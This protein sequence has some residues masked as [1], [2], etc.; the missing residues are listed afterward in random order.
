MKKRI[1]ISLLCC[2][3]AAP[4]LSADR[5]TTV[6]VQFAKG[7]SSAQLKGTFASYDSVQY[8]VNAR[9]D[10]QMTVSIAGSSNANF[11]VFGPGATPGEAEALGTGYVGGD[12]T[13]KLPA[14]GTYTI[15]VYQTRATARKGAK[16]PH[17]LTVSIK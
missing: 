16:V 10:Q 17:T 13:A 3:L 6:P 7:A 11:N 15:Q 2:F 8:T 14:S 12:W 5:V 4:A 1:V 9:Q